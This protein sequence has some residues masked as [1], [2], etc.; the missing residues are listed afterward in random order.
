MSD[1]YAKCTQLGRH[2]PEPCDKFDCP[3][4]GTVVRVHATRSAPRSCPA[5]RSPALELRGGDDYGS[6][7]GWEHDA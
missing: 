5:C 7:L 1:I 6:L 3:D 2:S 4:C